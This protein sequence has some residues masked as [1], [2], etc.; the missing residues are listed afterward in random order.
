MYEKTVEI[1]NTLGIHARPA[2]QIVR[3]AGK[4]ESDIFITKD[5]MEVNGKSIMGILML[6]CEQGSRVTIRANGPD[7]KEAVEAIVELIERKFDEE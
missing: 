4:F 2:S 5:G 7:E 1:T 6:A 3:T